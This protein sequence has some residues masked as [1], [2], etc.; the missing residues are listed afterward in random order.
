MYMT[1]LY[2]SLPKWKLNSVFI[3]VINQSEA[4]RTWFSHDAI[5][6]LGPKS[7]ALMGMGANKREVMPSWLQQ[8][9]MGE[10]DCAD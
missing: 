8:T 7:A 9:I 5:T 1:V 6:S 10:K 2:C 4:I 3:I